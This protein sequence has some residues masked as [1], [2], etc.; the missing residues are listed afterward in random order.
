M[1]ESSSA[2]PPVAEAILALVGVQIC[3][4]RNRRGIRFAQ[5]IFIVL[6]GLRSA[7][8]FLLQLL[9]FVLRVR[10]PLRVVVLPCIA[11]L[12]FI[13]GLLERALILPDRILLKLKGS[14]KR[15]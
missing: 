12:Q 7:G 13:A 9:L 3:L 5:R 4:G 8:Y 14:L 2:L 1:P 10:Q 11:L 15:R 6:I